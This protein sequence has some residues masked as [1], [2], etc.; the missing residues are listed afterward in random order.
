M[1]IV[2]LSVRRVLRLSVRL[3]RWR[4]DAARHG[5]WRTVAQH[6]GQRS[7]VPARRYAV[8]PCGARRYV[9]LRRSEAPSAA[10]GQ[11]SAAQPFAVQR[12]CA[13]LRALHEALL[14]LHE[15]WPVRHEAWPVPR[16]A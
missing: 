1:Q 4:C 2:R 16:E 3:V 15:A 14:A 9:A 10:R 7:F 11:Q 8:S 5:T 6:A 12:R 13:A